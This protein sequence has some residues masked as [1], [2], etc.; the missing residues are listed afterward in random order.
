MGRAT[1]TR[2]VPEPV[3]EVRW[4]LV[5][6]LHDAAGAWLGQQWHGR[7]PVDQREDL[8]VLPTP[9]ITMHTRAHVRIAEARTQSLLRVCLPGQEERRISSDTLQGVLWRAGGVWVR[10]DP[11][12][13]PEAAYAL[14]ERQALLLAWLHGLGQACATRPRADG[15]A[16]PRWS[17]ATWRA[18]AAACGLP[19]VEPSWFP[20]DV[21]PSLFVVG[22]T[23][24]PLVR[25]AVSPAVGEAARMLADQEGCAHLLLH[26][27]EASG[28]WRFVQADPCPDLRIAGGATD[29][30]VEVLAERLGL[31]SQWLRR[32][33]G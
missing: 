33:A 10:G 25:T 9:V 8:L 6:D 26:G 27:T 23:V 12:T 3:R 4:L 5:H 1:T 21:V 32:S 29:R 31:A 22:T 19:V 28:H 17:G 13:D 18:R 7:L 11:A 30:L 20:V 14:Q 24:V 15:L 16:G 2:A